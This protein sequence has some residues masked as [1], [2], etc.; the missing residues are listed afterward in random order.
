MYTSWTKYRNFLYTYV[1]DVKVYVNDKIR[2]PVIPLL[3]GEY[4]NDSWT[5]RR[6]TT[7]IEHEISILWKNI[8]HNISSMTMFNSDKLFS[9]KG[10]GNTFIHT[11]RYTIHNMYH[12]TA[13]YKFYYV[14]KTFSFSR[15]FTYIRFCPFFIILFLFVGKFLQTYHNPI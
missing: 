8:L 1:W 3:Y 14:G 2:N 5:R 12:K 15:T 7:L 10:V 6:Y 4:L 9:I 11:H 13:W